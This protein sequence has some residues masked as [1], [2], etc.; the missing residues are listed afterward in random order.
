MQH[1]IQSIFAREL[2]V[3]VQIIREIAGLGTVNR[4]FAVRSHEDQYIIRLQPGYPGLREFDKE[5]W[6]LGKVVELGI[7]APKVF[8]IGQA[9]TWS[10]MIQEYLPGRNGNHCSPT[11]KYDLWKTL[12]SYARIFHQV[13]RIE[14]PAWEAAEFHQHWRDKLRYNI[15]QLNANDPLL[16]DDVFTQQE[17][18][19]M[20]KLLTP[21]A[22]REFAVGLTHG[23]LCPRNV[24]V[25]PKTVYLL[26]WGT[27]EI[28]I[29]PH[30]EI[31]IVLMESNPDPEA[32]LALLTG[33]GITPKQWES[34]SQ[35]VNLLNVLHRLD[36][37]RWGYDNR[38]ADLH[39]YA[40]KVRIT[41]DHLMMNARD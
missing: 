23:D 22:I 10:F 11:E 21:L 14:L 15:Q 13:P 2:Q 26:D 24:L 30:T 39:E 38:V 3:T 34:L 8:S 41:Y 37:F 12:G 31:G 1:T 17:Q 29:V 32:F 28:N 20:K 7:P 40:E 27:A 19:R 33:L 35:E 5:K 4:V 36:K 9:G 6:C 18:T 25:D 16:L